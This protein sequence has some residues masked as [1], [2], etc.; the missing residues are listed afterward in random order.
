MQAVPRRVIGQAVA[1][2]LTSLLFACSPNDE[3]ALGPVEAADPAA[4]FSLG[5]ISKV[6]WLGDS[7]THHAGFTQYLETFFVTR[8]PQR[9][10][11]FSNRGVAGD[12]A[13]DVLSRFSN[14]IAEQQAE[15]AVVQLGMNDGGYRLWRPETGEIF[16][17]D[18]RALID[19]I[20]FA[21]SNVLLVSPTV[22]DVEAEWRDQL[23]DAEPL[24]SE[25]RGL[26][27]YD[28][29]I[30]KLERISRQIAKDRG[31]GY[32]DVRTP[33]LEKMHLGRELDPSYSVIPDSLHPSPDG[34]ALMAVTILRQILA[35]PTPLSKVVVSKQEQRAWQAESK[36]AKVSQIT[37]NEKNEAGPFAL[38][39]AVQSEALPWLV[40]EEAREGFASAGGK[41]F[42]RE[43]L[44]VANLAP[45][46]YL[47]SIEDFVVGSFTAV[48]LAE[49][50]DMGNVS[51]TPQRVQA[52]NVA[53]LNRVRNQG[54]VR[55]RQDWQVDFKN[56]EAVLAAIE[57][58][59][60]KQA[61]QTEFDL[62]R[63]TYRQAIKDLEAEE[64]KLWSEIREAAL[65]RELRYELRRLPDGYRAFQ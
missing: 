60:E 19:A 40:P 52:A 21:P 17:K 34:H 30:A 7:I 38:S 3:S 12:R 44:C 27:E 62:W 48:Q 36:G 1:L 25:D 22:Y 20:Q 14:G 54:P 56:R 61:A 31:A 51:A 57:H 2:G 37:A 53:E 5:E 50:L 46:D 29:V 33:L 39:F 49:G 65:P 8:Y 42:S 47:L 16:E 24:R 9:E 32:V 63:E 58:K 15:L 41:A 59:E 43:M 4:T 64:A 23:R 45:G 13:G 26:L 55:S 10:W 18:L 28:S 35:E 6:V 11:E